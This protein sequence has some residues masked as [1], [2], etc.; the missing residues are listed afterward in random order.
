[1]SDLMKFVGEH[2][3][4]LVFATVMLVSVIMSFKMLAQFL[5]KSWEDREERI[6]I[7]EDR[8][9]TISNGQR[10]AVTSAIVKQAQIGEETNKVLSKMDS[11]IL[12]LAT[13]LERLE[14]RMEHQVCWMER[15]EFS[16][17]LEKAV[18]RGSQSGT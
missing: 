1:M 9:V 6:R 7:L 8:V 13:G 5:K 4:T 10:E 18:R 15:D 3:F 14:Q 17:F 11:T 2:G 12:K 16:N